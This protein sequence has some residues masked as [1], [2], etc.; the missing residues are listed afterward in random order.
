[1]HDMILAALPVQHAVLQT[2][3]SMPSDLVTLHEPAGRPTRIVFLVHGTFAKRAQWVRSGS[4]FCES[5]LG[6]LG[7]RTCIKSLIWSGKN[8]VAARE[9][10]ADRLSELLQDS[11]ASFPG[12]PHVV[13]GHSHGGNVALKA[14]AA[15][16]LADVDIVCLSTPILYVV[17]RTGLTSNE[18]MGAMFFVI[19]G[20]FAAMAATWIDNWPGWI[21]AILL[22]FLTFWLFGRYQDA[23]IDL[24]NS[25]A[26]PEHRDRA[27]LLRFIGDEASL[28]LTAFQALQ[29]ALNGAVG[30]ILR[31]FSAVR[32]LSEWAKRRAGWFAVLGGLW[33]VGMALNAHD[34]KSDLAVWLMAP[35]G[36]AILVSGVLVLLAPLLALLA[37]V[38]GLASALVGIAPFGFRLAMASMWIELCVE[39]S[40]RGQSNIQVLQPSGIIASG[41][42]HSFGYQE[43]AAIHTIAE[44]ILG[45]PRGSA[46]QVE[47]TSP[48]LPPAPIPPFPQSPLPPTPPR[49]RARAGTARKAAAA[50]SAEP[51]DASGTPVNP[52][53]SRARPKS[54]TSSREPAT[55]RAPRARRSTR[56]SRSD[57][58]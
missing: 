57:S 56:P 48:P 26:V 13:I 27:L 29:Y 28:A 45:K 55:P 8:S 46:P 32:R 52:T 5:L 21:V 33:L 23:S 3:P 43:E 11:V 54:H 7:P 51:S 22:T 9:E 44:H 42:R 30:T 39:A 16:A 10:A 14:A 4:Q 19:L 24:G 6:N 47:T 2:S 25:I 35:A 31:F 49:A 41:M 34:S 58:D 50:A 1:M 38:I 40:P 18:F 36:T 12:V 53:P 15:P 20:P 17:P 37:L